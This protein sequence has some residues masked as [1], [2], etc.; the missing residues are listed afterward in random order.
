MI[1]IVYIY[2][3][4]HIYIYRT[5]TQAHGNSFCSSEPQSV[6]PLKKIAWK[7]TNC[8]VLYCIVVHCIVTILYIIFA[9]PQAS[10]KHFSDVGI[11][12]K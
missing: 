3:Y 2:I 10:E 7:E 11:L 1:S 4:I 8:I 9:G 5:R 6:E 12:N